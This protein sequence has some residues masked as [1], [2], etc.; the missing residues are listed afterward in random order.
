MDQ[1]PDATGISYVPPGHVKPK[2]Y[3]SI[4][5]YFFSMMAAISMT[6]DVWSFVSIKYLKDIYEVHVFNGQVIK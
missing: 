3:Q 6:C 2:M 5:T 1:C 4:F